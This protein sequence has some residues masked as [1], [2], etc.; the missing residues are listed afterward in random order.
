MH[1]D[2]PAGASAALAPCPDPE[3]AA[4]RALPVVGVLGGMGPAA[5][6]DFHHKI[7]AATPARRDQDHLPLLIRSMPQIP[8]R[9]ASIL[10]GSPSPEPAL[11]EHARALRDGGA[12]VIVIPCN[13]A[14]LWHEAVQAAV[15]I[16][17]LHIVDPVLRALRS[18]QA[19]DAAATGDG[20]GWPVGLLGTRATMVCGLY[21]RRARSAGGAD[22]MA[23]IDPL[24]EAQERYV[25]AG[26]H[27]VKAGDLA[28][29]AQLLGYAA[30]GLIDRGARAL[31][32][33]CTEIPLVLHDLPVPTLDA[34]QLL[35][36]ATVSWALGQD[37]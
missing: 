12:A 32:L 25:D 7:V 36:E 29:G 5:T 23:W 16:P 37:A 8:D 28:R 31:V 9:S 27:A 4:S 22:G 19:R 1:T 10:G 18:L 26:I 3:P 14:H 21:P 35:A 30:Q 13:T 33:A 15:D 2:L 24:P 20:A 6:A 11:I 34:T 17:V